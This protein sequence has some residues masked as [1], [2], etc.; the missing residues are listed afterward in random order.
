MPEVAIYENCYSVLREYDVWATRQRLA[1][2]PT[3]HPGCTECTF[4]SP[5]KGTILQ[6]HQLH[7]ARS[8]LSCHVIRHIALKLSRKQ[9]LYAAFDV[10][11][12]GR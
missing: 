4:D 8:L 7:S 10:L 12:D 1:V 3:P 11:P 2:V 5:L 6:P 9:L